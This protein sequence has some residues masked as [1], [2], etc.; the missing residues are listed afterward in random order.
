MAW[1]SLPVQDAHTKI[2]AR[3]SFPENVCQSLDGTNCSTTLSRIKAFEKGGV[4]QFL[5][6]ALR[7]EISHRTIVI[8]DPAGKLPFHLKF[9]ISYF[10]SPGGYW[11]RQARRAG[12]GERSPVVLFPS[13]RSV[14]GEDGRIAPTVGKSPGVREDVNRRAG[15]A[16][17]QPP[18][19]LVLNRGVAA[20]GRN[21]HRIFF[22]RKTIHDFLSPFSK[23]RS[24][25]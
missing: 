5:L 18:K 1:L 8:Q 3:P 6:V 14:H 2:F 21:Q 12:A 16:L 13:I 20:S 15:L 9:E 7:S 22:P 10:R 19:S 23:V 25:G 17:R 24:L 11:C 4:C